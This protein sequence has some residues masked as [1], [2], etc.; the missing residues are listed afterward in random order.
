MTLTPGPIS[1]DREAPS[2]EVRPPM[3]PEIRAA[4]MLLPEA[5]ASGKAPDLLLAVQSDPLRFVGAAAYQQI[6]VAGGIGWELQLHVPPAQRRRGIGSLLIAALVERGKFAR[7]SALVADHD[8][9][10]EPAGGHFLQSLGFRFAGRKVRAEVIL[11]DYFGIFV[12]MRDRLMQR[13]K[14]PG[15][16]RVVGLPEVERDDVVRFVAAHRG[17]S[18]DPESSWQ[19]EWDALDFREA[20]MVLLDSARVIGLWIGQT[21]GDRAVAHYR[22]IATD[23]RGGWANLVLCAETACRYRARGIRYVEFISNEQT[24]DTLAVVHL[25]G[26]TPIHSRDRYLLPLVTPLTPGKPRL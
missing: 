8:I 23:R 16:I 5:F 22:L 14:V 10:R 4:R 24:Q 26:S 12:P 21:Q 2:L 9:L 6:A 15:T 11:D 17:A 3:R 18:D 25:H 19:S 1:P 13:G 20:S 7:L